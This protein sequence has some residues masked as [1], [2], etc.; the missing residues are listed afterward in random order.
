MS[1]ESIKRDIEEMARDLCKLTCTC[2]ECNCKSNCKAKTYA[3]R[4]YEKGYRKVSKFAREIYQKLV[5]KATLIHHC[6]HITVDIEDVA[7][8]TKEYTE[9]LK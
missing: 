6:G 1:K 4:A 8:V 7:M 2:R 3:K 9:E 5:Q